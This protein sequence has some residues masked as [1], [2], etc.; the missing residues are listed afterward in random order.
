MYTDTDGMSNT[1]DEVDDDLQVD[2]R[3]SGAKKQVRVRPMSS[4]ITNITTRKQVDG[5]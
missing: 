5:L 1:I 3:Y 2:D 4:K